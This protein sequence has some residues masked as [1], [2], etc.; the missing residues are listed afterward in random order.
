MRDC[1]DNKLFSSRRSLFTESVYN[2]D[3]E[4]PMNKQKLDLLLVDLWNCKLPSKDD[5]LEL[6]QLSFTVLDREPNIVR[7]RTPITVCGDIHGQFY[8]LLELFSVGG[9]PPEQNF[10]FLGDYVDRGFYST[11]SLFLLLALK[12]RY[13]TKIHLLRGNHESQTV[14]EEYGFMEEVVRKYDDGM[15]KACLKVFCV[16]PLAA[17]IDNAVFCVHG[18]LSPSL[19][20]LS[21]IEALDRKQEPPMNGL[22]SDLL[23]SDPA[24]ITGYVASE[25]GAGFVFGADATRDFLAANGLQFMCRAHQLAQDGFCKWFDG[26]LYTV[27]SAPNYCY[28]GGNLACVFEITSPDVTKFKLFKEA[29]AAARGKIPDSK[30]PQYFL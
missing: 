18:G 21:Q 23:W 26:G 30:L 13:P 11:E 28:R 10:L 8:D 14:T 16:L 7:I 6:L 5:A 2:I 25:R 15:Y 20:N 4:T 27:W 29:P 1:Q 3:L 19:Q 9:R 12:A 22:F 24:D 17:L